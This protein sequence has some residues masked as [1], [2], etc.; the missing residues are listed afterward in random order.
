MLSERTSSVPIPE[1]YEFLYKPPLGSVR[2][3]VA[4]GGRMGGKSWNFGRAL[5]AHGASQPLRILCAREYQA[6]IR[7][8]VH[9]LLK[10]QSREM[11][12]GSFYHVEQARIYG[13]NGTEFLF[14]G[15]RHNP[16]AKKS[17]EGVD[18]CWLE[19]AHSTSKESW[20]FLVP[21]IRKE[22]SEIWVS[23]NPDLE[24]DPIYQTFVVKPPSE[25][26]AI[27]RRVGWE[28]N[29]WMTSEMRAEREDMLERDPEAEAHIW[30]GEPWTRSDAQVLAGRWTTEAVE[31]EEDWEGPY[32][33]ADWGFA[34]DPTVLVRCWIVGKRLVVDYD[35]R[36][37]GWNMDDIDRHFREVPGA[38]EHTIRGDS[39]RPETI[40][41]LC[42][43]GLRVVAADKWPGSV[44][45]GI[46]HLRGYDKIVIHLR[47]TG[48]IEEARLW[49]RKTDPRTGDVLPKL[50][51]GYD[52][53]W[54]AVRYA[55]A[56]IIRPRQSMRLLA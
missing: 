19:E 6:S 5:L 49:R 56:P 29:P 28:D 4:Y 7:D 31:P 22:R 43:R 32:Y 45:D 50:I 37:P 33:G 16:E 11:G 27:I 52:H 8:S 1:D 42:R 2:Y 23:F 48:L 34:R 40:N 44:E 55:L 15:L 24:T 21:T 51:D 25:D 38:E 46:L 3:R 53:G 14:A 26:R 12:L 54:D 47:C 39:S 9:Y 36:G 18:I 17:M 41:E 10:E 20:Q 35:E 13:S 30:G